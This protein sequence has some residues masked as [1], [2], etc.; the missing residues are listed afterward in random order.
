ML[1]KKPYIQKLTQCKSKKTTLL[2]IRNE[3]QKFLSD[4]GWV[5]EWDDDARLIEFNHKLEVF[6]CMRML[7]VYGTDITVKHYVE[8][9]KRGD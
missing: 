5:E 6:K 8:Y 4:K 3:D 1:D 7:Q 9:S 2:S